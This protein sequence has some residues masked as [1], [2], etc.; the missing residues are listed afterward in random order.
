[1]VLS[2]FLDDNKHNILSIIAF[3]QEIATK[4]PEFANFP[5]KGVLAYFAAL[6]EICLVEGKFGDDFNLIIH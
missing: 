4:N 3:I 5:E 6:N 1:M 2:T